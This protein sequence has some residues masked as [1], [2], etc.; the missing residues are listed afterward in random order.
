MTLGAVVLCGGISQ[1]MGQPKC[2]LPFGPEPMLARVVRLAGEAVQSIVVVAAPGQELPQLPEGVIIARDTISGRGPLQGLAAGLGAMP[3][4]VEFVYASATDAPF[5][6]PRWITRLAELIGADD[7]AMPYVQDRHHPLA[8][9]YRRAT[10]LPAMEALLAAG[11]LRPIALLDLLKARLITPDELRP[12]DP[13]LGTLLNLN[14]PDDYRKALA[15]AGYAERSSFS[16]DA[17]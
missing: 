2:W 10:V 14:T 4:R 1:R 16:T 11:R 9:L 7:I 17:N 3:A 12:I 13:K 6:E 8:A 5:L 15:V